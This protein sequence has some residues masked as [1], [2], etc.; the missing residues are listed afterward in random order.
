MFKWYQKASI[1]YVYLDDV[2]SS[3]DGAATVERMGVYYPASLPS[4][5]WFTRGWTLQELLAP[6]ALVFYSR[7]WT[8]IGTR[9]DLADVITEITQIDTEFFKTRSLDDFSVAQRMSWASQR[10]TTRIEDQAY[11][12]LGLF[13]VNM[14][15]LYGEGEQAFVRLQQEIMKESDDQTIFAWGLSDTVSPPDME[16]DPKGGILALSPSWFDGA[17]H[18]V[19][20]KTNEVYAPYAAT[21][22]GL[23]I[24]LPLLSTDTS[25]SILIPF[26]S[27]SNYAIPSLTLTPASHGK[28]AILNCH[29][30]GD[31]KSRF[32]FYVEQDGKYGYYRR[33][34]YRAGIALVSLQ[35][36]REKSTRTDLLIQMQDKIARTLDSPIDQ[37]HRIVIVQPFDTLVSEFRLSCT[38]SEEPWKHRRT[39]SLTSRI[40]DFPS[41]AQI[42]KPCALEYTNSQGHGFVLLFQKRSSQVRVTGLWA[43]ILVNTKMAESDAGVLGQVYKARNK[44]RARD[45]GAFHQKS[46]RGL[47]RIK[48]K[49]IEARHASIVTLRARLVTPTVRGSKAASTLGPPPSPI[50]KSVESNPLPV[51]QEVTITI[52]S[53]E[54]NEINIS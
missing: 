6:S 16:S 31:K 25:T 5:R 45:A 11:C 38:K 51:S 46:S 4:S 2:E 39:G 42:K 53:P 47:L 13:G 32:G 19:R 29:P 35:E 28:I 10:Q 49:I 12:L 17:G 43:L 54:E 20:S 8:S 3:D 23:Q 1:C 26:Q 27:V 41:I 22:K 14:P 33:V 24:S 30:S 21:N 40:T 18:I 48:P 52:T 50:L 44:Y 36:A 9:D 7:Y 15:L 37:E 34:N